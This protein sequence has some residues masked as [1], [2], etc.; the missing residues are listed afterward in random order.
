MAKLNE[1]VLSA[2]QRIKRGQ[3]IKGRIPKMV[4]SRARVRKQFATEPVIMRRARALAR[5]MF[6]IRMAGFESGAH[7]QSLSTSQKIAVDKL[8][9]SKEKAIKQLALR[10]IPTVRKAEMA[11]LQTAR[12][13]TNKSMASPKLPVYEQVDQQSL[14]DDLEIVTIA[15]VLLEGSNDKLN[16]LLRAGLVD[17]NK[18]IQY[19]NA[20]QDINRSLTMQKDRQRIAKLLN[21]LIQTITSD[22]QIFNLIRQKVQSKPIKESM[23]NKQADVADA[24]P[25]QFPQ[26]K[27]T[28]KKVAKVKQVSEQI[29]LELVKL[30]AGQRTRIRGARPHR[31]SRRM[32]GQRVRLNKPR[33][34]A[35]PKSSRGPG[36][37]RSVRPQERAQNVRAKA[38]RSMV[39]ARQR[40][41]N[42]QRAHRQ[43]MQIS[44]RQ[45]LAQ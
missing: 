30:G 27:P 36:K 14:Q 31:Q 40:K 28:N 7:Y 25:G 8:I 1:R 20:V 6:R 45:N 9:S 33:R 37:L 38:V 26:P 19:K 41:I 42:Q 10:L 39:Q 5:K 12:H 2:Q 4:R 15:E 44:Q 13:H 17:R 24:T 29:L 21:N 32:P 43:S 22:N 18:Y 16:I 11:R 34:M 35:A 23:V 3:Q